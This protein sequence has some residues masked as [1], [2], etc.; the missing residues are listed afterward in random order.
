MAAGK[1]ARVGAGVFIVA[2]ILVVA[3]VGMFM[4]RF[5][6]V[7]APP[8]WNVE[9]SAELIARGQYL[10]NHVMVCLDC[11]GE[12]EWNYFSGPMK[13]GTAGRGGEVFNHDMG[14]P[15]EIYSKNITPA[16]I[17]DWSDGEIARAVTSGVSKD[18][19]SLFPIMPWPYY[20]QASE[21]DI[22]AVIAYIRTLSPKEYTAPPREL[23]FPL[24]IIVRTMPKP[25]N[26][27]PETP[28]PGDADYGKYTVT[29]AGCVECHTQVND[30]GQILA[31]REFAGGREFKGSGL[32]VRSA[33]ISPDEETG[34]GGWT[35]EDFVLRFKGFDSPEAA[36][37]PPDAMGYQTVMPWLMYAG[38]TEDD[39][40]AIYDY[41]R[42]VPAIKNSVQIGRPRTTPPS[43]LP[44]APEPAAEAPAQGA[45]APAGDTE[46][47]P[48]AEAAPK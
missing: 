47:P 21:D 17:G 14:I 38:M 13:P 7:D 37:L 34:I 30:K 31:G 12:R 46:A 4:T 20:A 23:D 39:L 25:M 18:G 28:K 43:A 15:G 3:A 27:R 8:A 33:N 2:V 42:T 36:K 32:D 44:K 6:D 5:P 22:R 11:H 19:T 16:G 1:L 41:L 10:A 24:N 48:E 40:G 45:D 9:P 35:K 26:L 29:I